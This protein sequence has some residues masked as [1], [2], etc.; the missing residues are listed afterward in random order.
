MLGHDLKWMIACGAVVLCACTD[1]V[2]KESPAVRGME[3]E[4][5]QSRND[6]ETGLGCVDN[7]CVSSLPTSA[8]EGDGGAAMVDSRGKSGESCTRRADCQA[9]LACVDNVCGDEAE[10]L[11]EGMTP[12]TRGD[13]GESCQARND[14]RAELACINNRCIENDYD[15][16]VQPKECIRLQCI[17]DE[18]C[19]EN[20]VLS[21]Y[22]P[23]YQELCDM[24]D[25]ISCQSF[26]AVCVCPWACEA[27]ICNTVNRCTDDLDCG[28]VLRCF[29]GRCSQC[30]VS[31]DCL[32]PDD[33]CVNNVCRSGCQRNEQCPLFYECRS[34]ECVDVGCQSDRECYFATNDPRSECRDTECMSPCDNDAECGTFSLCEDGACVF[35]GCETDEEC[36]IYLGLANTFGSDQAVC[37]DPD[38]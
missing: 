22:C 23:M 4:S 17:E 14:C 3:G 29:S 26:D 13:R 8:T 7:R 36:R 32:D 16:T 6:C 34:G 5:C 24:G 19:C 27:N 15:V 1:S 33:Q 28:S 35:V 30:E 31:D 10:T 18:D 38:N 25:A 20:F 21:T 2:V 11:P 9:G 12:S 37:R